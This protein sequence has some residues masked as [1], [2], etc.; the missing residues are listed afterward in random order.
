M[1]WRSDN[2]HL[3][4]NFAPVGTEI[5]S[6]RLEVLEG[7]IPEGLA[8]AYIRNGPNPRYQPSSYNYPLEGDGMLHAVSFE[9]GIARYRNRYVRTRSFEIEDLAGHAVFGGLMS[10][11]PVDAKYLGP[12]D[13]PE[14]P[15]KASAFVSVMQHGDHLLALGEGEPAWEI[16]PDLETRGPWM[17]GTGSPILMGA[18]NR[19]HP[20]TGDLFALNY[21]LMSP[22][23]TIHHIGR[24]GRLRRSFDVGLAAPSMIH[25]FVLTERYLV[26]LIGP[27]VF[28]LQKMMEGGSFIQWR[29]DL[30]TRIAVVPLDGGKP[31]WFEAEAF[32]VFHFANGFERSSEIVIDYVR[33]QKLYFGYGERNSEP[34]RLH[35]LVLDT[36]SG[37]IREQPWFE[38]VVE[39]PRI[40]E[41]RTSVSNRYI[42]APTL[43][44]T[45]TGG[46]GASGTFN[47][48]LRVDTETGDIS[49]HDFGNRIAGEAVFIPHG[50]GETAG[51]LATYVYDPE[52]DGSELVLLDAGRISDEPVLRLRLPQR[53]PQGLH[54]AW[55]PA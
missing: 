52:T 6:E 4:G 14:N 16:G 34:P 22:T 50:N 40:D 42:F 54:G 41:R 26:L 49:A 15:F 37:R 43:T 7:A 2:P 46:N 13:D 24:D 27:A 35:R 3:T 28:D 30:G 39:F 20:V 36:T 55:V 53:V 29:G 12:D 44:E 48:L 11:S 23:V 19:V 21:D 9:N 10:P 51:W 33:H 18:H 32:F 25:D 31:R 1:S 38:K 5:D 17:A 47:C 8:G 45:L